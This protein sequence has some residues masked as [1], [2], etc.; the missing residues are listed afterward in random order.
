VDTAAEHE[1]TRA[2]EVCAGLKPG[3]IAIFD[4]GFLDLLHLRD[5]TQRGVF[6]VT[7]AKENLA[8]RK[9]KKLKPANSNILRD[10]I[11]RF[12]HFNSLRDYPQPLRRVV[13]RVEV[14][15]QPREMTFLTN[16][17]EW[18]GQSVADL[19]RCRWSIEVFFKYLK[20]TLQL[21]DFL[22]YSANAVRWQI[23]TALIVYLLLRYQ[24][25]LAQWSGHFIRLFTILRAALWRRWDGLDLLQLYGTAGPRVR[26]RT[27]PE[28]AYFPGFT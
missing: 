2:R 10:E 28:Q 22:G 24:A 3:E 11:V 13:A 7:R 14:D 27:Q 17:L 6:W 23:W 12:K 25:W 16:H 26:L 18:S 19:Y 15:G 8:V 1:A 4:K 5:L 21:T 20:Q 9:L